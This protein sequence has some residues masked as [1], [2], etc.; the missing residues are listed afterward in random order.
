M[1]IFGTSIKDPQLR[2]AREKILGLITLA[3]KDIEG[4]EKLKKNPQGADPN[5]VAVS[6]DA[7]ITARKQKLSQEISAEAQKLAA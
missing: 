7:S 1:G 6:A 2:E 4:F 5:D 3:Q